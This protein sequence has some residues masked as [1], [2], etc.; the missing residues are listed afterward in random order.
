MKLSQTLEDTY[1]DESVPSFMAR[2]IG[3][4]AV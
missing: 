3:F 4:L 1:D 2:I